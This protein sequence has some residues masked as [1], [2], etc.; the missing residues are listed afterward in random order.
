MKCNK[1]NLFRSIL[2]NDNLCF[3]CEKGDF[4]FKKWKD[5]S[6]KLQK[7]IR[8]EYKNGATITFLSNKYLITYSSLREGVIYKRVI[9]KS[10]KT[11]NSVLRNKLYRFCKNT[12]TKITVEELLEKIGS[13]PKCYLTKIPINLLDSKSYQLDHIIPKSRGGDSSLSNCNI[14]T[15][16]ANKC[17]S[18]LTPEEFIK[19]C[20]IIVENN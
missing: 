16:I 15:P 10:V 5:I 14:C 6:S 1:C 12:T 3:L 7:E 9:K 2:N 13:D 11:I 17:K 4:R 18:N 8:Q 19:L 20:W